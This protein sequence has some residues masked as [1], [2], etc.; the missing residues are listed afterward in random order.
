MNDTID[1]TSSQIN[2]VRSLLKQYLPNV[3]VCKWTSRPE[4]DL[5]IVV[6]VDANQKAQVS[7]LREAFEESNLPFRV[8]LFVW[9]EVPEKFRSTINAEHVVL[10]EKQKTKAKRF[11]YEKLANLCISNRGIQTIILPKNWTNF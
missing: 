6:F 10:Q 3:L 5:D 1:L 7:A 4:S 2:M 9:D 8:D 11:R